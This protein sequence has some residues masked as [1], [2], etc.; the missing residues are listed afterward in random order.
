MRDILTGVQE[1]KGIKEEVIGFKTSLFWSCLDFKHLSDG[2]AQ[3]YLVFW[4][5]KQKENLREG[6][7]ILPTFEKLEIKEEDKERP[8]IKPIAS[9]KIRPSEMNEWSL[10]IELEHYLGENKF[11]QTDAYQIFKI[12]TTKGEQLSLSHEKIPEESR[13]SC[14]KERHLELV[15]IYRIRMGSPGGI[16]F[17][18]SGEIIREIREFIKDV[19]YRNKQERME[20]RLRIIREY[21][22]IKK[23]YKL[24]K[25]E[26]K[27]IK[28]LEDN[29]AK[30][31]HLE[32]TYRLEDVRKN[33]DYIPE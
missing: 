5:L 16:S 21:L 12:I 22:Q 9:F 29:L 11:L 28:V 19:W 4:I 10:F 32:K 8:G 14:P 26:K 3:I 15:L 25:Q 18:G 13:Y 17:T 33:L 6:I 30:L 2:L 24:T 23:E 1:R 27:L 20:G 7:K 31:M